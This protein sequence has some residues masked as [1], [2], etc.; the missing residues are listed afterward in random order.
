MI[1]LE[2]IF[3]GIDWASAIDSFVKLEIVRILAWN[4]KIRLHHPALCHQEAL[5]A[6][7]RV[8]QRPTLLN[9]SAQFAGTGASGSWDRQNSKQGLENGK[10]SN[11]YVNLNGKS[12]TQRVF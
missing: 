3:V 1:N 5:R 4:S 11:L 9:L 12:A 10:V 2:T 7:R 6:S 8:V